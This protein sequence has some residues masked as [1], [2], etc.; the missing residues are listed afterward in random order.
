MDSLV[1]TSYPGYKKD[2]RNN[3][4]INTNTDQY[5]TYV[6]QISKSKQF[7]QM[8]NELDELKR[9]VAALTLKGNTA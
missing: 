1:K 7:K 5:Q 3:V 8:K 4:I 9:A 2:A 6:Q